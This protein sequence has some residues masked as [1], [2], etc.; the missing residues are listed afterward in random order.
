[1]KSQRY[2][3]RQ[4]KPVIARRVQ[5]RRHKTGEM[6]R[7]RERIEECPDESLEESFPASDPPS[8]TVLT[9]IMLALLIVVGAPPVLSQARR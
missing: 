1:V 6:E 8:W 4:S 9:L 7:G 2:T 3:R 5:A